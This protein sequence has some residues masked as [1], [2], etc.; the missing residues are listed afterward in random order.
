MPFFK[1]D[2][3]KERGGGKKLLS[4]GYREYL[5]RLVPENIRQELKLGEGSTWADAISQQV[6]MRAVGQ[7]SKENICFTAITEIRE[8]TEGKTAERIVATGNEELQALQRA[9]VGEPAGPSDGPSTVE[10]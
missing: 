4:A 6:M 7:V 10:D 2:I 5:G 8:T 9:L 1:G 3:A